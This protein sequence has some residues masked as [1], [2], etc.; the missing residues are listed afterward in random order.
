MLSL[1]VPAALLAGLLPMWSPANTHAPTPGQTASEGSGEPPT[2]AWVSVQILP[3]FDDPRV[4]VIYQGSLAEGVETP[5][6]FSLVIP[7]GAQIHMAG[8]VDATGGHIHGDY[9]TTERDGLT[10]VAYE[11]PV[12]DFYMEFYYDPIPEGEDHGFTY[13]VVS[14]WDAAEVTVAVQKPRRAEDFG[15]SP[16]AARVVQDDKGFDYHVIQWDSVAAGTSR[17][18]AV[19]YRKADREPSAVPGQAAAGTAAAGVGAGAA[20]GQGLE[21]VPALVLVLLA[22]ALSYVVVYLWNS[23]ALGDGGAEAS[24]PQAT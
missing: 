13:P 21:T 10:E 8:G 11:L 23:R 12:P 3:E 4:L 7:R 16:L 9:E 1:T 14:P 5:A 15:V 22:G 2:V 19:R 20:G 24:P 6:D 17:E 18:V